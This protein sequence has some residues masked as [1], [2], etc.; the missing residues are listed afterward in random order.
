MSEFCAVLS[1]VASTQNYN[2]A[3]ENKIINKLSQS[4]FRMK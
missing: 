4:T 2:D 3:T 1:D